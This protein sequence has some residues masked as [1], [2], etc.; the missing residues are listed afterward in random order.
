[1]QALSLSGSHGDSIGRT[2]YWSR[3]ARPAPQY[4]QRFGSAHARSAAIRQPSAGQPFVSVTPTSN[5]RSCLRDGDSG[6]RLRSPR[7]RGNSVSSRP[8]LEQYRCGTRHRPLYRS[9]HSSETVQ[10]RQSSAAYPRTTADWLLEA[11]AA[12]AMPRLHPVIDASVGALV[13]HPTARP[14]QVTAAPSETNADAADRRA[15]PRRHRQSA[16]TSIEP[17]RPP[18]IRSTGARPYSWSRHLSAWYPVVFEDEFLLGLPSPSRALA[19][20]QSRCQSRR[21]PR[22]FEL[23]STGCVSHRQREV[24]MMASALSRDRTMWH[25]F[26]D[27]C[28]A[29]APVPR[30]SN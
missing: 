21:K 8:Q 3:P 27:Y 16:L 28:D 12:A 29:R 14:A 9:F 17:P 26:A 6:R 7:E 20:R 5:M 25:D 1:M 22:L 19:R 10:G 15:L 11:R 24:L 23:A 18:S 30:A 13:T 4:S 2:V